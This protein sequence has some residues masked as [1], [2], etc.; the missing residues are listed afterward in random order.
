MPIGIYTQGGGVGG[1]VM[2]CDLLLLLT[3]NFTRRSVVNCA[4]SCTGAVT[5][6]MEILLGILPLNTVKL[7]GDIER[8]I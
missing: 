7:L 2:Q 3:N 5:A 6:L 1:S 8:D 4:D